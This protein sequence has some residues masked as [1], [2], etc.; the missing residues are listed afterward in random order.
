MNWRL[1]WR[2][3][4]LK[5]CENNNN[6]ARSMGRNLMAA[7][8][9][10]ALVVISAASIAASKAS[11]PQTTGNAAASPARIASASAFSC[12]LGGLTMKVTNAARRPAGSEWAAVETMQAAHSPAGQAGRLLRPA[13]ACYPF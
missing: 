2:D 8:S 6:K 7:L 3:Q 4:S 10:G 11:F 5:Q 1:T 9:L 12:A 13:V